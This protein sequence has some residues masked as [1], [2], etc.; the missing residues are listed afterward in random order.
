MS[1]PAT[2][3]TISLGQFDVCPGEPERNLA[4]VREWTAEATRRGSAVVVF[5]ELW[6]TGYA[7]SRAQELGSPA[8]EGRFVQIA[9]LAAQHHLHIVGSMLE[10][11]RPGGPSHPAYNTAIWHGPDGAALGSYRKIHLFRLP[12]LEEDRAFL[13]GSAPGTVT[14][15]WGLTG[16]A[17]CYDLRFPELFRTYA[18]AG[19]I[20]TVIPAQ[21]PRARIDHWRALLRAR[22]IENQMIVIGCNRVGES[23]GQAYGGCSAIYDAWGNPVVEAGDGEAL[24]TATVD[25][26][27]VARLRADFPVLED[28]RPELYG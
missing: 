14:L 17:I 27:H 21:W 12:P 13:P 26:G 5:P 11:D 15:P 18:A 22:A 10:L 9:Q 23:E 6:D 8:T 25:I 2:S 4:T 7:L 24:V 16:L 19:V 28:R 3:L 20:L 1:D